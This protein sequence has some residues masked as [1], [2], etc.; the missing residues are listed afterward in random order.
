MILALLLAAP[1]PLEVNSQ[2]L[3]AI[4]SHDAAAYER[5]V[6]PDAQA[7]RLVRQPDGTLIARV[8]RAHDQLPAMR[9][10]TR[11]MREVMR[12]VQL[13][14]TDSIAHVWGPY[15][16]DLEGR[17]SHCGINAITMGR[18]AGEWR[19][20]AMTWTVEPAPCN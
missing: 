14:E 10:E 16:F 20:T 4:N 7:I 15:T 18:I 12:D 17:R 11:A 2:L 1:T 9:T 5:L 13:L 6:H 8:S 3:A 19:I